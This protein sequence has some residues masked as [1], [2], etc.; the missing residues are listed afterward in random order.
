MPTLEE[1]RN[2]SGEFAEETAEVQDAAVQQTV[3]VP[4]EEVIEEQDI[5]LDDNEEQFED[6]SELDTDVFE[7]DVPELSPKEKTAFERRLERERRKLEEELG[8]QYE[9]KY[10]KHNSVIQKLGGDPEKIEEYL[11]QQRMQQEVS[12]QAQQMADFNGWDQEQ[13][14]WYINDQMQKRQADIQQQQLQRELQELR[15]A[16]EINDLR[17]NPDFPGII[18]MKKD[19]SEMVSK[20][21]GTLTVSQAYWALGG[22]NRAKQMKREAEQRNAMQRRSRVVAK[23]NPTAAS[24]EQAIPSNVLAEAKR[25]GMSEK[26]VRELMSFEAKNINEYRQKKRK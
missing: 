15:L 10:S 19:I 22:E 8:K 7:E 11:E 21:N 13:T 17:D 16:N 3:D 18:S 14:Q 23:D 26:E 9:E 2:N 5:D 4:D 25:M 6:N 24:T 1:F 12:A 20:S